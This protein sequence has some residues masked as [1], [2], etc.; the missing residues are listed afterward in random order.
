[1]P[2]VAVSSV[3]SCI[4]GFPLI[5]SVAGSSAVTSTTSAVLTLPVFSLPGSSLQPLLPISST[6]PPAIVT[7]VQ[8]FSL[9]PCFPPIPQKIVKKIQALEFVEMRDLLPDNISLKEKLESLPG[10]PLSLREPVVREISSLSSWVSAFSTFIAIVAEVHPYRVKDMCAYMRLIVQEARKFGGTGWLTY[11]SVF[12]K[13]HTGPT[14]RWDKIDPSLHIAHIIARADGRTRPAC[15][16]CNEIDHRSKDCALSSVQAPIRFPLSNS[17][18]SRDWFRPP[19]RSRSTPYSRPVT[20]Q[21]LGRPVI[22]SSWNRG[23]C[24]FPG[25]CNYRHICIL[26]MGNHP[27]RSCR[28]SSSSELSQQ[29]TTS[30][31][32]QR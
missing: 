28:G 4:A 10:R 23:K 9:A 30:A 1:M 18:S 12:R 17:Y 5:S 21:G 32:A 7:P 25:T 13:N 27:A 16:F 26:C 24:S 6:A 29:A 2:L 22:C 14:A 31:P 11:D 3:P 19:G 20:S 8:H 15:A